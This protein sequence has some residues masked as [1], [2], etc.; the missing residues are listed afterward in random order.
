[1][2]LESDRKAVAYDECR[3]TI[4]CRIPGQPPERQDT[5]ECV[6]CTIEREGKR[7]VLEQSFADGTLVRV[8]MSRDKVDRYVERLQLMVKEMD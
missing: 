2:S 7:I 3:A 4:T 1:M 8:L 6:G 5:G